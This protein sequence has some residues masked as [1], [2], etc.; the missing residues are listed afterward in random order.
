MEM[1]CD[2]QVLDANDRILCF[3]HL[4]EARIFEC[5]YENNEKRMAFKYPCLDYKERE[6]E[7]EK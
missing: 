6:D 7:Y 1:W 3:A 4:V 2:N 5:P